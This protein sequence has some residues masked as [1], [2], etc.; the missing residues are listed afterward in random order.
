MENPFKRM[1]RRQLLARAGATIGT[2]LL[3]PDELIAGVAT[4]STSPE[5]PNNTVVFT[6]TTVVTGDANRAP[7]LD[8]SLAIKDGIIA[9]IGP[10]DTILKQFSDAEVIDG[11]NKALL[12]GIINCH[13]HLSAAVAR[14][15]NEDFG[16]PNR[17]G[18]KVQPERLV[19]E[20]ERA[21]MS[22]MAA[23]HSIRCGTTT[24]MEYTSRIMS[25]APALAKT[26][27]RWV[28]AEGVND[29]M[30]ATVMSPESFAASET[31]RFSAQLRDEGMQRVEDLFSAW[32]NK[33]NGRIQVF[34]AVVHTENTSPE[35]MHAIRDF[36]EKHEVN[37]TI[38]LNQTHAE[39]NYMMKYHNVRP[40]EYLHRHDFLGPRLV[41]A[42]ARY[43]NDNEIAL[44]GKTQTIISH[45]AAMAANRGVSPPIPALRDAGCTICLGTDNNNNDMFAVMKVAMLTERILRNDEHPGLLP[46][47]ED[48][49]QDA[50]LGGAQ[51]IGQANAL[52][53][54]EIGRKADV[55]ILNTKQAHLVPSGRILSA[56]LH[57]GQPSDVESV[58]V[59]G[60]FIMRDHKILTVD[61]DSLIA[62]ADKVGKRVW[63]EVQ[64]A[65][66][67][68]PP[69]RKGWR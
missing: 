58:M 57:N 55:I 18:L 21:L 44:L 63:A 60:E 39:I 50:S 8:V 2:G 9:G 62:E 61:E 65:N 12:P 46:Q 17:A 42:H 66:P 38:H 34:P 56:W 3:L 40:A 35:L 16:F 67:V 53:L 45:Q 49:L 23:L 22:V 24:V 5:A 29:R 31:P 28:F 59:D 1:T 19:S 13:A 4:K 10:T 52:G 51:A 11:K 26:G 33:N 69:G 27:L 14:G 47:P 36:A 54:L 30:D 43:V 41:A 64:R 15:F 48:I 20:E 32:H 25:E 68:V 37:Y 7:M 6:H